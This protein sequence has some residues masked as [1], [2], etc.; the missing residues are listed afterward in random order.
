M[1]GYNRTSMSDFNFYCSTKK[2]LF[3]SR[4][5]DRELKLALLKFIPIIVTKS[6]EINFEN[7]N[8]KISNI[9][10]IIGYDSENFEDFCQNLYK[11]IDL[12]QN[13]KFFEKINDF[14]E[15]K[16]LIS[17][18]I[19]SREYKNDF[20]N[21]YQKIEKIIEEHKLGRGGDRELSHSLFSF[22]ITKHKL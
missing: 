19:K 21:N 13:S 8:D 4:D 20:L 15:I 17:E 7:L 18:F 16:E 14:K 22:L 5:C 9:N 2:S 1:D 10:S 12:I 3:D 11:E 6:N